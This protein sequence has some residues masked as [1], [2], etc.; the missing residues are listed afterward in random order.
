[1]N[2]GLLDGI[3]KTTP[4][5]PTKLDYKVISSSTSSQYTVTPDDAGKVL[6]V[7]AD[8]FSDFQINVPG[9]TQIN[10]PAF[11]TINILLVSY[12]KVI[13]SLSGDGIHCLANMDAT[14]TSLDMYGPAAFA[15]FTKYPIKGAN[16]Q[17]GQ[18]WL[19][20]GVGITP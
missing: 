17:E 9:Y 16:H 19:I 6:V 12:G 20:N 4:R 2:K 18:Y 13:V 14:S 1:M 10:F 5:Y 8:Q 7:S 15:S 11:T 3:A